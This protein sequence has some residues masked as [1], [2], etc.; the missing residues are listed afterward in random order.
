MNQ[1]SYQTALSRDCYA[2]ELNLVP[3]A[4][5]AKL[6]NRPTA[7]YMLNKITRYNS[8][9]KLLQSFIEYLFAVCI[10]S[11]RYGSRTRV[12]TVRGWR[13]NRLPNR[14]Y[15][16]FV[17]HSGCHPKKVSFRRKFLKNTDIYHSICRSKFLFNLPKSKTSSVPFRLK[18]IKL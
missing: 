3:L 6:D 8:L 7:S 4:Y 1:T 11:T 5:E 2:E 13:L 9:F 15:R 12:S 14:A 18:L 17:Y 16:R 10:S